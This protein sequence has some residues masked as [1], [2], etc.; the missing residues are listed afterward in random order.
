MEL[1]GF[2]AVEMPRAEIIDRVAGIEK[3]KPLADN[4]QEKGDTVEHLPVYREDIARKPSNV[5][6][7]GSIKKLREI[8]KKELENRWE[9]KRKVTERIDVPESTHGENELNR[10]EIY[11]ALKE[12]LKKDAK[13]NGLVFR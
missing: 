1:D 3:V 13:R 6:L 9:R 8:K 11:I 7:G 4:Q 5:T 10:K 12:M 2:R